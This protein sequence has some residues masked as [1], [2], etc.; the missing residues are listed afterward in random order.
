MRWGEVADLRVGDLNLDGCTPTV[1]ITRPT[2]EVDK[3]FSVNGETL[4]V[5]QPPNGGITRHAFVDPALLPLLRQRR[6]ELQREAGPNA[7]IS[8]GR[9]LP[10]ATG[11]PWR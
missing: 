4:L 11:R 8:D 1:H 7:D 10:T 9:L 3:E 6:D 2:V 5:D